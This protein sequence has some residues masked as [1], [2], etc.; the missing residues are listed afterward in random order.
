[1]Q[2]N[3]AF[4][5]YFGTYPGADGIPM[6]DG[7]P[8]VCV[9]DPVGGQCIRPYHDPNDINYGGP[10]GEYDSI[11]DIDNGKMDGFLRQ[12]FQ[13]IKL[14]CNQTANFT[15]CMEKTAT[16]DAIGYHDRRELPNYWTYADNFVLQDRMFESAATWS[17]PAHLFIISGWSA[18]CSST[19][20]MSCVNELQ[21]PDRLVLDK[22]GTPTAVPSYAWTDITFLLHKNKVSWAYYLDEGTQPDCANDAMFCAEQPQRASMENQLIPLPASENAGTGTS[23]IARTVLQ[24]VSAKDYIEKNIGINVTYVNTI[25]DIITEALKLS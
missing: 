11:A 20:P 15:D 12:Q 4:D 3:R 10:H 22:N 1:M 2:E 14:V 17:L 7:V 16:V 19:D 8:T 5:E 6:K 18:R 23:I 9:P 24:Q 13:G 25:D 21:V